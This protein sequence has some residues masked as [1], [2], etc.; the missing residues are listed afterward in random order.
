MR[1]AIAALSAQGLVVTLGEGRSQV[2][3]LRPDHPLTGM[4]QQLYWSERD[5]WLGLERKLS[6]TL[7]SQAGVKAAWLYGSVARGED[8]PDSDLDLV[9]VLDDA[10]GHSSAAGMDEVR[11]CLAEF[12][13]NESIAV[14]PGVL[15]WSQL[16]D[17][18]ARSPD[19][20][21]NVVRDVKVLVGPHPETAL[22]QVPL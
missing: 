12:G 6:E 4:L 8:S 20:W 13:S 10:P 18:P 19:W 1:N 11:D 14:S 2:H 17:M 7:K 3:G 5:R 15:R 22:A 16:Q 21:A 9:V